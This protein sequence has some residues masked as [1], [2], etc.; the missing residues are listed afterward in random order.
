MELHKF[1]VEFEGNSVEVT[2]RYAYE[3]SEKAVDR[4]FWERYYEDKRMDFDQVKV[5]DTSDGRVT[6]WSVEGEPT[7]DWVAY[8]IDNHNVENCNDA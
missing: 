4:L 5:T 3:A 2:A 7:V 6:F 8:E 1:V